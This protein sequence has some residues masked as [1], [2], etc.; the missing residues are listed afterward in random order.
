[1]SCKQAAPVT[2]LTIDTTLRDG[3]QAAGVYF[4]VEEKLV[5]AKAL[6]AAGV[7]LLDAGFPVVS[8]EEAKAFQ[9]IAAAGLNAKVYATVRP[10][11]DEIKRAHELGAQGIFLFFPISRILTGLIQSFTLEQFEEVIQQA[12]RD[13]QK[14]GLDAVVVLEDAG[15]AG[16]DAEHEVVTIL[17]K[18]GVTT[19]II[20]ESVGSLTPWAM[21]KKVQRLVE[22]FPD[23]TLGVHCHDD[24]GLATANSL[25]AIHAGAKYFSGTVNGLGERAGNAPLE[26]MV[27]SIRNLLHKD[28]DVQ[29]EK[30][31]DL[32]RLVEELSG[33]IISPV[34]AVCGS[35]TF[36]CESG[37]HS[38]ALLRK[39]GS[40]EPYEP[41]QVGQKR[42]FV[43]GKHTGMEYLK[44]LLE[45]R[46]VELPPAKLET[47]L[48]KIKSY[49]EHGKGAI[50][51]DFISHS[52]SFYEK[53]LG[54]SDE[55]F[56]NILNE[57]RR[58]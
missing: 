51:R 54:L 47:L 20:A 57:V 52:R 3:E 48:Q 8:R 49:K 53:N 42:S 38:R 35:S 26:E 43:L 13:A 1:M 23:I 30:L 12:V 58:G 27:I 4:T 24:Y 7:T 25:A 44:K 56:D 11:L 34:K 33:V 6:D 22:N 36:K 41:E 50:M 40:Y 29:P 45:E 46:N 32:C 5:L 14:R 39:A 37:L 31:Y 16:A 19:F 55:E 28:T 15:R 9:R 18:E 2:I 21:E 17:R 10:D